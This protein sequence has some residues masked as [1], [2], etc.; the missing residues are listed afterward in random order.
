MWITIQI[1][2]ATVYF[3]IHRGVPACRIC[4]LHLLELSV[5]AS[6]SGKYACFLGTDHSISGLPTGPPKLLNQAHTVR[7]KYLCKD[8][9][10]EWSQRSPAA[11]TSART[12]RRIF[13]S[14]VGW[15]LRAGS[16]GFEEVCRYSAQCKAQQSEKKAVEN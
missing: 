8:T 4:R 6:K 11:S 15:L 3:A 5:I 10:R 14:T 2:T 13:V 9:C 1:S 7:S 12:L 16:C